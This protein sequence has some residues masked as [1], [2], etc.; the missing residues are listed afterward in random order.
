MAVTIVTMATT[1]TNIAVFGWDGIN[2]VSQLALVIFAGIALISGT[3]INKRQAKE[4]IR[5]NTTLSETTERASKA[6]ESAANA[7]IESDKLKVIVAEAELKR[8]QAERELLEL[9]ERLAP[10]TISSEQ[11]EQFSEFV[12]WPDP[13]KVDMT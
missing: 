3:I 4:L 13:Q 12:K 9:K 1:V 2:W 6:Q 8:A 10:R 5:L 11:K 7:T